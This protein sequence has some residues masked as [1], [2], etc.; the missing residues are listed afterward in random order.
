MVKQHFDCRPA[1]S[2]LSICAGGYFHLKIGTPMTI[3]IR[4]VTQ[5]K[6]LDSAI[7]QA[8][9][10][11]GLIADAA[12]AAIQAQAQANA[13]VRTGFLR[14]SIIRLVSGGKFVVSALA[15]YAGFV[16]YGT[17]RAA[18]RPYLT[19]AA[20]SVDLLAIALAA[21]RQIGL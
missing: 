12:S 6:S 8:P 9:Q 2:F 19:P 10:L 16:E 5:S 15:S 18:A 11:D 1:Y 7:A 4:V 13:P 20:E 3:N 17:R 21:L 14:A